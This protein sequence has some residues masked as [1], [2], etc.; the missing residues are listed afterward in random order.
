MDID[1]LLFLQEFRNGAGAILADFFAK[2]TF[3]SE[4][5]STIV[6]M[7]VIYWCISKDFGTYLLMGWSGNRL[8]NGTLKVT[9]CVYRPWIRDARIIPYGNTQ[10]TATGYSFPSGHSMNAAS[11]FG[12]VSVRKDLPRVLRIVTGMI[13]VLI[14]FSRVFV[15]VHT[16]QD[17][18]VGAA[19]GILVMW[20]TVKLMDWIREHPG[21]DKIVMWTGIV[22]ALAVALYAR[23]KPYPADYDAEGKL[24]VDGMKMANDTFKAVGWCSAFLTGWALERRYVRFSTDVSGITRLIRLVCGLLCYYAVSLIL[25]PLLKSW[26]PGA[27]GTVISCF[28]QMFYIT[29]LFPWWSKHIERS[30]GRSQTD[31]NKN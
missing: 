12:G 11:V 26:I 17:V 16:P 25:V 19:A 3:L 30:A 4:L 14:C 6:I 2:M 29:F 28:V 18:L 8:V 1:I 7:A 15:G 27:A 10:A 24:L 20:L 13:I 23:F 5:N 9:A 31:M 21:K 22:L